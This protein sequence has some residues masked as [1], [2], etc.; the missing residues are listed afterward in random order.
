MLPPRGKQ[1]LRWLFSESQQT[2]KFSKVVTRSKILLDLTAKVVACVQ[3]PLPP[4][5][6]R[7]G[8]G[9]GGGDDT[10]PTNVVYTSKHY[11]LIHIF[12]FLLTK[13]E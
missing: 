4:G 10:Q 6:N 2:Q 12:D 7:G 5:R 13:P 8:R 1:C 3:S 11:F 9:R